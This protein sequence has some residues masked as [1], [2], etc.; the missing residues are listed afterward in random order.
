MEL[1]EQEL[2]VRSIIM[3]ISS[4]VIVGET[5]CLSDNRYEAQSLS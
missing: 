4:S 3:F 2:L 1:E 5:R